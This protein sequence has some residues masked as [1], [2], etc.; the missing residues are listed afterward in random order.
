MA[1]PHTPNGT[2]SHVH[3][4]TQACACEAAATPPS[5][6]HTAS[7]ARCSSPIIPQHPPRAASQAPGRGP[8]STARAD[9]APAAPLRLSARDAG[10]AAGS[11]SNRHR[12]P[13]LIDRRS[14]TGGP[15]T[16]SVPAPQVI[17]HPGTWPL[18]TTRGKPSGSRSSA[19]HFIG[20]SPP[21][22]A[23]PAHARP[24][25]RPFLCTFV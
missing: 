11:G 19:C 17:R 1:L 9:V 7:A 5:I 21:P 23:F 2:P 25:C 14:L 3:A 16:S 10:T 6:P 8:A 4:S 22:R 13:V 20:S 15:C 12:F 18:R 24:A